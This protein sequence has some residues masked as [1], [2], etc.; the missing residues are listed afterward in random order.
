MSSFNINNAIMGINIVPKNDEETIRISDAGRVGIG[1]TQ[2]LNKVHIIGD[3]QVDNINI[4]ENTISS[5]NLN[6][7]IILNPSGTGAIQKDNQGNTRGDYAIDF[8]SNRIDNNQVSSGNYSIILN[9]QNNKAEA[10]YS[11][12]LGGKDTNA[13]LYGEI[14]HSN[15]SFFEIGDAQHRI[16]ILRGCGSANEAVSLSLNGDKD[17]PI[18]L[19]IPN[20]ASWNFSIKIIARTKNLNPPTCAFNIV[21]CLQNIDEFSELLNSNVQKLYPS[22][23]NNENVTLNV[24][25]NI[26]NIVCYS[27]NYST[28]W[29]ALVDI[30]QIILPNDTNSDPYDCENLLDEDLYV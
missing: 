20:N 14:A 3:L 23:S 9:G 17:N 29:T 27:S 10:E 21:G 30:I 6:G 7:N 2:P 22:I 15:G 18:K 25:N 8:Q 11:V 16:L 13:T 5:T 4:D 24:N 12:I 26:L 1:I 28:Y 19:Q